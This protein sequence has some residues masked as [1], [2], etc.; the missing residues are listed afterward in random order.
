MCRV[1]IECHALLRLTSIMAIVLALTASLIQQPRLAVLA[2]L[3]H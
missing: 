2:E 1:R 3:V